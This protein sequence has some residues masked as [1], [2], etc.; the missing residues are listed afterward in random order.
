MTSASRI[1][2]YQSKSRI[3]RRP[4]DVR[5]RSARSN[6]MKSANEAPWIAARNIR[7]S[8]RDFVTRRH[9]NFA[10]ETPAPEIQDLRARYFKAGATWKG[11]W[12]ADACVRER[13][14][15]R[16]ERGKISSTRREGDGSREKQSGDADSG[17]SQPLS[18][19]RD[20]TRRVQV[21]RLRNIRGKL[22]ESMLC[23]DS[24]SNGPRSA[25]LLSSIVF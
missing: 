17:F 20:W 15:E 7:G 14:R 25:T 4:I 5:F 22:K 11:N 6:E 3:G 1:N 21:P 23:V 13:E 16:G 24:A 12:K 10:A 18:I 8:S 19:A 2:G 9:D